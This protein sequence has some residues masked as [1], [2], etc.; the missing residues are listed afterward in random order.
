MVVIYMVIV[1]GSL[2]FISYLVA[3]M[4]SEDISASEFVVIAIVASQLIAIHI[5]DRHL[6]RVFLEVRRSVRSADAC[7]RRRLH[8]CLINQWLLVIVVETSASVIEFLSE[9]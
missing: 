9:R 6:L 7:A 1:S 2:I 8:R 3:T 5:L 4:A